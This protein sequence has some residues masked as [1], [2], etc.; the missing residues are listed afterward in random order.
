[1]LYFVINTDLTLTTERVTELFS[2]TKY[3]RIDG[4]LFGLPRSKRDDIEINYDHD[5][6]RRDA[7]I[8]AYVNDHP[9][10]QWRIV[11]F[12]LQKVGLGHQAD[13]VD[14]TYVQGTIEL[15]SG[16]W[17]T[18]HS[19]SSVGMAVITCIHNQLLSHC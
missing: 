7:Y 5:D 4:L 1:M 13:V 9:C 2:T 3:G 14:R 12:A 19:A 18:V 11:S 10:P 8:D 6:Q 17:C 16:Y 15:H